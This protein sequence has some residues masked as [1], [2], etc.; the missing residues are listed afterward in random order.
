MPSPA[1]S[2]LVNLVSTYIDSQKAVEVI[3]RQLTACHL[4]AD[5]IVTADIKANGMRFSTAFSL[6]VSDSSKRHELKT[7]LAA[8]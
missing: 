4:T 6:Y 3:T 8:F 5:S 7:K 2:T 1:Y